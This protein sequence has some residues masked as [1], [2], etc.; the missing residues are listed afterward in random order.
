MNRVCLKFLD[1]YRICRGKC[2]FL[3]VYCVYAVLVIIPRP[4]MPFNP[5]TICHQAKQ[6]DYNKPSSLYML[7]MEPMSK[8]FLFLCR[9][10]EDDVPTHILPVAEAELFKTE[11]KS[12]TYGSIS[13]RA[14]HIRL[15]FD[16]F[17]IH[18]TNTH[19]NKT[20]QRLM[21]KRLFRPHFDRTS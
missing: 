3:N 8:F 10:V 21:E 9:L 7:S 5:F 1:Y 13:K 14:V 19:L 2:V 20:H 16:S 17:R 6:F 15:P 11:T 4:I 18:S 12:V